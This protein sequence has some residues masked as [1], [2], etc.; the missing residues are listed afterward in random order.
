MPDINA[1]KL[2]R[3]P[4]LISSLADGIVKLLDMPTMTSSIGSAAVV[5]LLNCWSCDSIVIS[6]C[7]DK[8]ASYAGRFSGSCTLL[9]GSI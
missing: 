1:D 2:N 6:M 5:K 4:V 7:L 8:I 3:L 9:E